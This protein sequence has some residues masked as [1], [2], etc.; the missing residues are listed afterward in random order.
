MRVQGAHLAARELELARHE[1]GLEGGVAALAGTASVT[2]PHPLQPA[3]AQPMQIDGV[4]FTVVRSVQWLPAGAGQSACDGGAAVGFPVL[5]VNV[6]VTWGRM[7]SV[8][9]VESNTL[10][11]PSKKVVSGTASYIAVKVVGAAGT[12]QTGV[13]VQLAGG[14]VSSSSVTADDG[15]AVFQVSPTTY[16][17]N[18]TLTASKSGWVDYYG[19][20]VGTS[21]ATLNGAGTLERPA[22]ISYDQ[23][24][25][26]VATMALDANDTAAGYRLPTTLPPWSLYNSGL[27]T[28]TPRP[29]L[30]P[31][32][33]RR[34][35]SPGSGRSPAGTSPGRARAA[36]R[37]TGTPAPR[38]WYRA[39]GSISHRLVPV[40]V[41]VLQSNGQPY[42]SGAVVAMPEDTTGCTTTEQPLQLGRTANDGTLLD[43]AAARVVADLGGEPGGDGVHRPGG[44]V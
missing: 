44:S 33:V 40:A 37:R 6:R 1:F 16:P 30:S 32:P 2:N 35:R 39:S 7:G 41:T 24:A 36:A 15:C 25:R 38:W 21:S 22:P 23:A 17:Q 31:A 28:G 43:L 3:S 4:P 42:K 34:R 29:R 5:A 9:P 11:T 10:L 8:Q 27:A 14:G 20:A 13:P 18:Y 12:P 26:L 19:N